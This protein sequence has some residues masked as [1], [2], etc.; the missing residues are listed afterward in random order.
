MRS[1]PHPIEGRSAMRADPDELSSAPGADSPSELSPANERVVVLV[2]E[3]FE[4]EVDADDLARVVTAALDTEGSPEA[5]VTLVITDDEQVAALNSRYRGVEGPTDVLAFP[6]QEET[7]G[8]V[9]APEARAYLGDVLIALPYARRQAAEL[10]RPLRDELR[11]LTVHGV[12]HL[13]GYDHAEP[14]QEAVMWAKQE[15]ILSQIGG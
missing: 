10:G 14:H 9:S 2:D 11:L 15:A 8:F 7:P 13:L 1:Q 12:L 3:P 5:E 4:A 6:A